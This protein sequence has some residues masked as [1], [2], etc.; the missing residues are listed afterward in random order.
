MVDKKQNLEKMV[1][2]VGTDECKFE[3]LILFTDVA[4]SL[5][6]KKQKAVTRALIEMI[7]LKEKIIPNIKLGEV[8]FAK[9]QYAIN[10]GDIILEV[11]E[12]GKPI[13]TFKSD[14]NCRIEEIA[15]RLACYPEIKTHNMPILR[16]G[17]R[18]VSINSKRGV[19][20]HYDHFGDDFETEL[21]EEL[22][23]LCQIMS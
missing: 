18:E 9:I 22:K 11:N 6:K 20:V 4:M 23:I 5:P 12:E 13:L 8:F 21:E 19:V 16:C 7:V 2:F 3:K 1:E 15:H 14:D 17:K 10:D